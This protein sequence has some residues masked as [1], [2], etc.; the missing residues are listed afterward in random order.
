MG[1]FQAKL[2]R[3]FTIRYS[4]SGTDRPCVQQTVPVYHR[5]NFSYH[6]NLDNQS[7]LQ[8][9]TCMEKNRPINNTSEKCFVYN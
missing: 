6:L 7:T 9:Q 3:R 1:L 5:H 4:A 8:I 2:F